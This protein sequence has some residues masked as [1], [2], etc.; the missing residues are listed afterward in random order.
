MS[1]RDDLRETVAALREDVRLLRHR[2]AVLEN[3]TER[4][5]TT[6]PEP[7][8]LRVHRLEQRVDALRRT[9]AGAKLRDVEDAKALEIKRRR[10]YPYADIA[11][12]GDET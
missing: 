10:I 4:V 2:V 8:T 5:G 6:A 1:T 3:A 9:V 7:I 11:E 12:D